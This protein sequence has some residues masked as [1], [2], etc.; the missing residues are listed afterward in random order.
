MWELKDALSSQLRVRL[1][2]AEMSDVCQ[3]C[4]QRDDCRDGSL[5]DELNCPVT[6]C[7]PGTYKC[8]S[9]NVC[10]TRRQLCDGD[11]DC[12]DSSD[13]NSILCQSTACED[14]PLFAGLM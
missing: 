11:N 4:D 8:S 5:S 6:T 10:V 12:A 1:T 9:T 3:V 14:G 2:G 13:E 7:R